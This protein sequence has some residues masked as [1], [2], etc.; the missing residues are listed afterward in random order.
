[1]SALHVIMSGSAFS[2]AS[3]VFSLISVNGA[4]ATVRWELEQVTK[5]ED[6]TMVRIWKFVGL[7]A[8]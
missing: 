7:D 5:P 6:V 8:A 4:F 1:M 2:P 3:K